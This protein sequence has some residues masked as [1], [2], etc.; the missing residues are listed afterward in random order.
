MTIELSVSDVRA[1]LMRVAS[2][3]HAGSGEPATMLLG[4]VFHEVFADIVSDDPAV[5]GLRLIAESG[6]DLD[7]RVEQ[8]LEHVWRRL[9]GPRLRRHAAVLQTSSAPVLV[10]WQAIRNLARWMVDVVVELLAQS[11]E[12]RAAANHLEKL[13]QA[14]I[15]L[16][17]ELS[18]PGWTEPVRLVGIADSLL[19][20]PGKASYCA[21]ELKLGRATPVVDMGQAA[22]YHLILTR[23]GESDAASS[24]ALMRFSPALEETVAG[25]EMLASAQERLLDLIGRLTGVAPDA[26]RPPPAAPD[27]PTRATVDRAEPGPHDGGGVV[28]P[29]PTS[30]SVSLSSAPVSAAEAHEELGRR[31]VRAFR[32]QGVLIELREKPIAGPRFLRFDV[33][34]V[35]GTRLDGLRKRSKEAQLRLG[36]EFEPIVSQDAGHLYV[37]IARPDPETVLFSSVVPQLPAIDPVRGSSRLPIG[38]DAAGRLHF[39]DIGTAGRSHVLAAGTAG[40]GKSEWLRMMLAGLIA[41]NTPDTL[42]LVTLD[43]KLAAFNDLEKSRFL[44]K[45]SAWW[46]PGGAQTASELFE[47]LIGEMDRRF[48]LTREVGADNLTE[49]VEKTRKPVSRIVCVCDEYFALV[50]QNKDEKAQIE[51]AVSL[52]GAKARAAGIHLVLATQQPSRAIIS[53]AIQANLQCRVAL[54][55]LS[56]IESNMILGAPGAE[57][58]T[59]RGDLLYKDFGNPVRLQAPYLPEL[60]RAGWLGK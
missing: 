2:P 55:L 16:S 39:V 17:C 9:V 15:P 56:P 47:E 33:R 29:E 54:T 28:A 49:Y 58:L 5:S 4:R 43:P 25:A 27:P 57:R 14:E 26:A 7:R 37:D 24:L 45:K 22:L 50:A 40:S 53:G 30:S 48:R 12:A 21:I 10:F 34:L 31:L 59:L 42:R 52:L 36:L 13:L 3:E 38:V 41:S 18:E 11:P 60:E 1:A 44:W 6:P 19:R 23:S 32:D 8:L 51:H 20:V 35:A 46:I